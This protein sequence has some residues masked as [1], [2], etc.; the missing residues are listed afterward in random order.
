MKD[1]EEFFET[2]WMT[3]QDALTKAIALYI[4]ASEEKEPL[5]GQ[6]SQWINIL[7]A[8]CSEDEI[9]DAKARA[10]DACFPKRIKTKRH[11]RVIK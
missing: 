3:P 2:D 7:S 11:L 1:T 10:L 4:T 9:E 6:L 8:K 5:I